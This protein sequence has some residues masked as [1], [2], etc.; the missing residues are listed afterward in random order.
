MTFQNRHI[1]SL[2]TVVAIMLLSLLSAP[3]AWG[4]PREKLYNRPYAD[5]KR[6]HLG[7]SVGAHFQDLSFTHNGFVAPDGQRW[8]AEVPSFSPGF[9]VNVLGDLRLHKYLNLRLTPGMYF[10]SKT[11]KM[12]DFN[13]DQS[14]PVGGDGENLIPVNAT[15]DI[16]SAYVVVPID[17]KISGD[18]MGNTRPYVTAGA[19]A[20]FDVSKKRSDYLMFNPADVYLT[21]GLG[22]D[23][24]LPFFKFIPEIKFCFGLTDILRHDRPDLDLDPDT[25]KMTQSLSKVKSNMVVINF[26]FE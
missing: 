10:G 20:A 6:L 8:V 5:Q 23:F 3:C 22:C 12:M 11:V 19:M 1:S 4:A 9:C 25:F 24:Y 7:F 16:K 15:Q 26:Y 2:L 18:R 13:A 21:I 17:L 14:A